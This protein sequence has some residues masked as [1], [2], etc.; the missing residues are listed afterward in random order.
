M[1]R[2]LV[3]EAFHPVLQFRYSIFTTRLPGA[4]FHARSATLP[5]IENN[6][7]EIHHGNGSY[8]VKGKTHW[9]SIN[10]SCYHFE[11]I[12]Q[13]EFWTYLQQH[14]L[15]SDAIDFRNE[16][17]KHD[18]R[19]SCLTPE[20][21]PLGTWVLHGAFYENVNFGEMNRSSDEVIEVN[22]TIRYDYAIFKPFIG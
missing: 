14:Q 20:E 12:T 9:N 8:W 7:I 3:P 10:I 13:T 1:P 4:F 15:V 19:V 11:G 22:C 17:Y 6:P 5:T 2:L 16:V 21:I 18:L